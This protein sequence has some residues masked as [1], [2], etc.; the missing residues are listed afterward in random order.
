MSSR[1]PKPIATA[2]TALQALLPVT[3][4]E[5]IVVLVILSG[6]TIGFVL[7]QFGQNP[8]NDEVRSE[9]VHLADSLATAEITTFTGTT[10]DGEPA[11]EL[12]LADTLVSPTP[13]YPLRPK[14]AKIA[15]G[16]IRLNSATQADLMRLPGVGEITAQKIIAERQQRRF[17]RIEDI[18]R[19]KGIGKKKFAAMKI[20]LA[21]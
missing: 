3:Q 4:S 1:F 9:L 7:R 21:L 13:P 17:R 6:L 15:S 19:V 20:F 14:A 8:R 10:P 18:M 11:S 5:L 2:L 16:I 12:A